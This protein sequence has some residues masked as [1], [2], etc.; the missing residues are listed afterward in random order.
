VPHSTCFEKYVCKR[1]DNLNS[2]AL[3]VHALQLASRQERGFMHVH[4]LTLRATDFD[5]L[6]P[7]DVAVSPLV[8]LHFRLLSGWRYTAA[9]TGAVTMMRIK[10][11]FN[12]VAQTD[13][14]SHIGFFDAAG[15]VLTDDTHAERVSVV[16][17]ADI[18][19]VI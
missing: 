11:E 5:I 3:G 9:V 13:S 15:N 10:R 14:W 12:L 16:M 19:L 17:R 4:V 6:S 2:L 7:R 8:H 18:T 1:R